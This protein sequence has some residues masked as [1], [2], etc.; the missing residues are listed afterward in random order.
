VLDGTKVFITNSGT[1]LTSVCIVAA[2]TDGG[3]IHTLLVP[4]DA[5]LPSPVPPV[6]PMGEPLTGTSIAEARSSYKADLAIQAPG[7]VQVVPGE[8]SVYTLTIRNRGP[9][10]ATGI[11]L[12]NVLPKGV[13]PIWIQ[14]AQPVCGRQERSAGC[15]MGDVHGGDEVTV[16]LDLSIGGSETLVTG[17]QLTGVSLDL[18]APTCAIDQDSTPPQATCRLSRLRPGADALVRVG[19]GVNTQA[20]PLSLG[21][22]VHTAT[23]MANEAD[24]N[25]TNNRATFTMTADPS[26]SLRTGPALSETEGPATLPSPPTTD[27]IV[28]ADGPS[29][30]IAGQPSSYTF[31]I[32]NRGPLD[33][34]GVYFEDVLPPATVLDG[35]APG[36]PLCEQRED[37]LTCYLRD[38]ESGEQITFTLVI[39]GH[40][41]QPMTIGLDPLMP[42]WPICT[43]LKERT[44]LHI[45]QCELGE[46]K[47]GQAT[48]VQLALVATG[49][50]ERMMANTAS[51]SANE[52]ELSPL[53]NT[54][55][56]TISVQVRADL[57]I[58]STIS[59]PAVAGETLSYT[60]SVANL[61]P[62]DGAS[63]VLID[64]LP[65][66]TALVSA[67][68]SRGG[69]C[70]VE[71][72]DTPTS[73]VTCDLGRL[74][75]GH[76]AAVTI[77][78]AVDE[79]LT[80]ALAEALTHSARVVTA[81]VDPNPDNNAL[82][83]SIPVSAGME[84]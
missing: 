60:L 42:G 40:A 20:T 39:T 71:R 75:G 11:V 29:S 83:E 70:R 44:Y 25:Q 62:S 1:P 74:G 30:V 84:D 23:V 59:G 77:V 4:T 63:V 8:T 56:T 31:T 6:E 67:V 52:A 72:E 54:D 81:S 35:Y 66:G 24:A 41:R 10:L 14:P 21:S 78:V 45:V 50:Q 32:T 47:R 68:P 37:A 55:T 19:V 38:L 18:P 3:A 76:L 33:A 2:K 82:T 65:L 27:L 73:I 34:S 64:T 51:V 80:P 61:G 17:T 7:P 49:V 5:P 69:D 15:D 26:T 13:I 58:W 79:S 12:I 28:Q 53:D 46:L 48:H 43:V 16:T 22:L 36:L 9:D 57:M